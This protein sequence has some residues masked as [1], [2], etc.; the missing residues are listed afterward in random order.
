MITAAQLGQAM[1]HVPAAQRDQHAQALSTA[2]QDHGIHTPRQVA[3]FLAQLG[4]ASS[5]MRRLDRLRC[6]HQ[7]ERCFAQAARGWQA[8]GLNTMADAVSDTRGAPFKALSRQVNGNLNGLAAQ[9]R[10]WQAAM[11]VLS[12][13][14]EASAPNAAMDNLQ[15]RVGG[16]KRMLDARPDTIDFRDQMFVPTLVQVPTHVPLGSYLQHKI[17]VLH[18]GQTSGCTGFAL[19]TIVHYLMAT[20]R[21][22]PERLRVSPTM[23]YTLARRYDEWPGEDYNGSSARGAMKG[24]HK[25]GVALDSQWKPQG[26][27]PRN[28]LLH[29]ARGRPLGAYFRVNHKDLVAMHAAIAEVGALFAS[30]T[31]HEGWDPVGPSGHIQPS[32]KRGGGHAFAIVAF[33]D[34]GFW[35]QNSWGPG[36]GKRGFG[37]ISY[38]DWLQNGTDVWVARLGAPMALPANHSL[39]LTRPARAGHSRGF[40]VEDLQPHII[41]IGNDGVLKEGGSYGTNADDLATNFDAIRQT[42]HGWTK[43]RLL[44]YAHGGLVGEESAV[45]RMALW[46]NQMLSQEIF[47]VALVWHS[48]FLTT[49]SNMLNEAVLKRRSEGALDKVKDF[50]LDRLDDMLEPL[51]RALLGKLAWSEM[52]ENARGASDNGHAVPQLLTHVQALMQGVQA[53]PGLQLHL[54]AHSAGAVL[55]G[56]LL[57]VMA[58]QGLTAQSC[59][60]WAPACTHDDFRTHYAPALAARV[61]HALALFV[62]N[63]TCEQG[64]DVA[65]VYNKSL[66]YLVSHA[67]EAQARVP[68]DAHHTG[69]P[70][71]GMIK[72]LDA[73]GIEGTAG[74][75]VFKTPNDEPDGSPEASKAA[76]HSDFDEDQRTLHA[77][78]ARVRG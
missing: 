14:A 28:E 1:R 8:L 27:A 71:L 63:D 17:P 48:D 21:P 66:L 55:M 67:F 74:V 51:A 4:H 56:P 29:S 22:A 78:M 36:W 32:D 45:Q 18:Q 10:R 41:S 47:P 31:T 12:R 44:L 70:L 38:D 62:L 5:D 11:T 72:H 15:H 76:R 53:V 24:W 39:G 25:H 73:L 13:S 61:L 2:M 50:M 40:M 37:R 65:K 16:G 54:A 69:T 43:P 42:M 52:K 7:D 3:S 68:G 34:V 30:C 9:Q 58:R 20:R 59:T 19:A 60:L 75:D 46:R 35:I 6:T 23:L 77:L 33:D 49:V 64:D 57:G 26:K